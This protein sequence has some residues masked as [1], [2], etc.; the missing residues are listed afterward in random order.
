MEH[1]TREQ[2]VERVGEQN[3]SRVESENCEWYQGD[4]YQTWR[5]SVICKGAGEDGVDVSL[6]AV[7]HVYDYEFLDSDGDPIEDLSNIDWQID[8]YIVW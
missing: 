6:Y 5:A 3:V 2:A 4:E 7:Y 1:L 8:H